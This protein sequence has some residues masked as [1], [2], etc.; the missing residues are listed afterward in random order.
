[1]NQPT[2][3]TDITR[4]TTILARKSATLDTKEWTARIGTSPIQTIPNVHRLVRVSSVGPVGTRPVA[5]CP[6]TKVFFAR[7]KYWSASAPLVST[8][9]RAEMKLGR[10]IVTAQKVSHS[11]S[12]C[13]VITMFT[14]HSVFIFD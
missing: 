7:K 6:D 11:L 13:M 9:E 5:A 8:E 14:S 10:T 1:M 3:A 4:V 2:P 12:T